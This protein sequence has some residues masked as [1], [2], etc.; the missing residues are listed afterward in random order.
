MELLTASNA[1][2]K[3]VRIDLLS[4]HIKTVYIYPDPIMAS[5]GLPVRRLETV[6]SALLVRK[7]MSATA[8]ATVRHDLAPRWQNFSTKCQR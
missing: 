3:L 6:E 4:R 5:N 1:G 7:N 2:I 8:A